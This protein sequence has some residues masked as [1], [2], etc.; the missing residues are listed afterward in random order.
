[1]DMNKLHREW[2][3][4]TLKDGKQPEFLKKRITYYVAGAEEWKYA[5]TLEAIASE[6]RTLFLQSNGNAN[7]VT[8]SGSLAPA[9]PVS[10]KPDH[11]VYDP[12]DTRP[13]ELDK[14]DTQNSITDQR[15]ALTLFGNGLIYHSEPFSQ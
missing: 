8:S 5:D 4:W 15:Y 11:F 2:Y 10:S 1:L 6:K 14:V 7:D 12:L 9:K 13:A 3:D